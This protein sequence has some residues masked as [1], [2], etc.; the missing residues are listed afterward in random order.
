[1]IQSTMKRE[2]N[3]KEDN[4]TRTELKQRAQSELMTATQIAF[5][6]IQE[7]RSGSYIED[8]A[9][10]E[11]VRAEMD[12]QFTRMERLFNYEPGSWQRGV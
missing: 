1:M 4:M 6:A 2:E 5:E 9:E 7:Y 11:M 10:R 8:P 3:I 12:K